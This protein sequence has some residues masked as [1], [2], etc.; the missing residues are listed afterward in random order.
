MTDLCSGERVTVEDGQVAIPAL[1]FYWL[2]E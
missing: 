2:K 1:S